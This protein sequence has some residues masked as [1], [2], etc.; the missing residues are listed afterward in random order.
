MPNSFGESELRQYVDR[1]LAD[2]II[3]IA[4][5]YQAGSIVIP[6]RRELREQISSEI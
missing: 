6:E 4:K 5:N 1:L 3:A 2:E